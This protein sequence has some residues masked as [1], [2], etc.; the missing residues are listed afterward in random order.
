MLQIKISITFA[1]MKL[2]EI[3]HSYIS[4]FKW[5]FNLL[6]LEVI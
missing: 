5:R 1:S 4:E 6:K 3:T 2:L